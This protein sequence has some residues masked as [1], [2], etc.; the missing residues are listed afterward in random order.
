MKPSKLWLHLVCAAM[1]LSGLP[2][3]SAQTFTLLHG[4]GVAGETPV[5]GV[6]RGPDGTVYGTTENGGA[7]NLG[8]LF[9]VNSDGSGASN[10]VSFLGNNG[11]Y[12]EGDLVLSGTT[13]YGTTD[14]GGSN[15]SGTVF[16][17]QTDGSG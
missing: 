7:Q 6:A 5:G 13:L 12:P 8:T 15:G 10:L 2:R 1:A 11:S 17:V 16:A 4:F 9:R 3:L 14:E